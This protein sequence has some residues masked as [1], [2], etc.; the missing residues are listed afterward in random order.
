MVKNACVR[1]FV[2]GAVVQDIQ[3]SIGESVRYLL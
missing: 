1:H 3:S 2:A